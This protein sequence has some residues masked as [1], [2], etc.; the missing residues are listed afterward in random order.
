MY[1][2]ASG[3]TKPVMSE[4]PFFGVIYHRRRPV[5]S[6]F[7]G[8]LFDVLFGQWNVTE[9]IRSQSWQVLKICVKLSWKQICVK[10]SWKP[11]LQWSLASAEATLNRYE[12]DP[13][14]QRMEAERGGRNHPRATG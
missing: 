9:S 8:I 3:P 12:D 5:S 13:N 11:E 6:Q 10:L 14:C 4:A 2:T 7:F 1:K